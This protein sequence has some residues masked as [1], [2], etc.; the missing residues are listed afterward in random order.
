MAYDPARHHRRSI[1]LKEYDYSWVGWYYITICTRDHGCILGNL[2]DDLILENHLGRMVRETWIDLPNHYAIDLDD[3]VIMPNHIHGIVIINNLTVGAIHES[4]LQRDTKS[5]RRKMLL[6]KI[7]GRFKMTSAKNA[8]ILLK[9]PSLPFWQR[10]F[11]EHIIRN[12]AD[13]YRIRT[14]IRNNPLQWALDEENPE[15]VRRRSHE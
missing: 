5:I 3:F 14:Y 2:R 1:R 9:K 10:G 11:Y 4:P 12:D 15:N 8:N 7:I 13:L 6:S